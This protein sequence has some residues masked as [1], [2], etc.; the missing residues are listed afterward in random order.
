M[1]LDQDLLVSESEKQILV[2]PIVWILE[3]GGGMEISHFTF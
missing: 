1:V 2:R 3:V